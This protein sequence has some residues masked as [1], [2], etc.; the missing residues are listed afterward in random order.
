MSDDLH[1]RFGEVEG[2]GDLRGAEV[3]DGEEDF[4]WEEGFG[5]PEGP[6]DAGIGETGERREVSK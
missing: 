6:A 4:V 1:G 2:E 3:V 5:T